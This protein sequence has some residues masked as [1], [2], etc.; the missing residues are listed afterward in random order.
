M[1]RKRDL[2]HL[3]G[4]SFDLYNQAALALE[5]RM[6]K[7]KKEK[8][9]ISNSKATLPDIIRAENK[10]IEQNQSVLNDI[11]NS[12]MNQQFYTR[13]KLD[14]IYYPLT[15]P[16]HAEPFQLPKIELG[17][18]LYE[19]QPEEEGLSLPELMAMLGM[20]REE[21]K[22]DPLPPKKKKKKPIFKEVEEKKEFMQDLNKMK[23]KKNLFTHYENKKDWW[24]YVRAATHLVKWF[25]LAKKYTDFG[26]VRNAYIQDAGSKVAA[27]IDT[28]RAWVI[29]MAKP[30]FEELKVDSTLNLAFTNYSGKFKIEE[31]SQKIQFLF[32]ILFN[33]IMNKASSLKKIPPKIIDILYRYIKPG[34]YYPKKFLSTFEI[35][36]IDFDFNGRLKSNTEDVRGMLL[37]LLVFSRVLVQQILMHIKQNFADFKSYRHIEVTAKMLGSIIHFIMIDIY[38][39][40]PPLVKDIIS[41]FNYYRNYHIPN[42]EL[43]RN[44]DITENK[45]AFQDVDELSKNLFQEEN[46]NKFFN[47][48]AK[49]VS[50]IKGFVKKWANGLAHAIIQSKPEN[51]KGQ[52]NAPDDFN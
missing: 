45:M 39:N 41:Q 40:S 43:E 48:N 8:E 7:L 26:K 22:P 12:M 18:P 3:Y 31:Q 51:N 36:R 4:Q 27:D 25:K 20:M 14:N 50:G 30:F 44:I 37:A 34:A 23:D 42:A 35:N 1:E 17:Q 13:G 10:A 38:K 28:L 6:A 11:S 47:R 29:A 32:K 5:S 16:F 24:R 19:E 9:L 2:D 46:I 15:M 33:N 52:A 21:K 49:I